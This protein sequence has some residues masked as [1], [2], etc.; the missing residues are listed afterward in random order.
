MDVESQP[1][2]IGGMEALQDA[3]DYPEFAKKARIEGRVI[4]Q[5]VV[6]KKGNVQDPK[7]TRGV[8]KLLNEEAIRA[9]KKQKFK[10]G[11]QS[12]QVVKVQMS[13]PV[14]FRLQ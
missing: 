13:L 2:L 6:D 8:H 14:T 7:V 10:P 4:V 12:G 3:V 1:E 5:F 9:V 11:K